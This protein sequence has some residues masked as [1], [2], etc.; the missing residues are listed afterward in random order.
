MVHSPARAATG[1]L[2]AALLACCGGATAAEVIAGSRSAARN[3]ERLLKQEPPPD[4][5]PGTSPA[6][7]TQTQKPEWSLSVGLA[8]EEGPGADHALNTPFVLGCKFGTDNHSYAEI[9][10]DGYADKLTEGQPRR[11]ATDVTLLINH[12][13]RLNGGQGWVPEFEL[14][15]PTHGQT[16]SAHAVP[17][18]RLGWTRSG[19]AL[20]WTLAAASGYDRNAQPGVARAVHE[21]KGRLTWDAT[22]QQSL[23]LQYK[24]STQRGDAG[25]T[26]W[27]L[28]YDF[29]VIAPGAR[30]GPHGWSGALL[31][32][33]TGAPGQR[34]RL[35]E[36]DLSH[37]F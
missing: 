9:S 24:R 36:F 1:W 13:L 18:L 29:P 15:L 30:A 28:E 10:G 20:T 4:A 6:P 2:A 33:T 34:S 7:K 32:G 27:T 17:V 12:T 16:G 35:L 22:D 21:F 14:T 25:A 5:P 11:G 31:L 8:H 23:I 19:Q 26:K 3:T 37:T